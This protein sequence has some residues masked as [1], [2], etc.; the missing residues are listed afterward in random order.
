MI[1]KDSWNVISMPEPDQRLQGLS[2]VR[3]E[4]PCS[5]WRLGGSKT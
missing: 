5:N 1:T 3:F 4:Y 2:R